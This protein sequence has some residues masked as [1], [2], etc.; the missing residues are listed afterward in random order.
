MTE[1][2]PRRLTGISAKAYQH[3]ADRA[4]TAALHSIPGLD[5]VVRKLIE[6]RYERAFRQAI[7]LARKQRDVRALFIFKVFDETRLEGLQ[8]GVRYADGSPKPSLPVIQQL[9]SGG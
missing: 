4:A 7:E 9:G 6:F 3:P 1:P 8:S 2:I 5:A